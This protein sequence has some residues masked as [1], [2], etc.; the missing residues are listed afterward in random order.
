[1]GDTMVSTQGDD[2]A[3]SH[4]TLTQLFLNVC[5]DRRVAF[6]LEHSLQ[7][8]FMQECN[9]FGNTLLCTQ[10]HSHVWENSM[11]LEPEET[12]LD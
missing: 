11:E 7:F 5:L 4:I 3:V 9:C 12:S 1:M 6:F 10:T 8:I 2:R